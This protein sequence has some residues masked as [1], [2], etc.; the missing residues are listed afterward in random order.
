M[1][2]VGNRLSDRPYASDPGERREAQSVSVIVAR[3]VATRDL[4]LTMRSY[5]G[6]VKINIPRFIDFAGGSDYAVMP[7]L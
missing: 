6:E 5:N 1:R 3:K 2:R 4:L 7:P